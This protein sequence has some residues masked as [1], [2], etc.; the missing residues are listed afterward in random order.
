MVTASSSARLNIHDNLNDGSGSTPVVDSPGPIPT[1]TATIRMAPEPT[2]EEIFQAFKPVINRITEHLTCFNC[3]PPPSEIKDEIDEYA[4][5]CT[6]L[7]KFQKSVDIPETGIFDRATAERLRQPHCHHQGSHYEKRIELGCN[8]DPN[9]KNN[10]RYKFERYSDKLD[11]VEL[12]TVFITVFREWDRYHPRENKFIEVPPQQVADITIR[13]CEAYDDLGIESAPGPVDRGGFEKIRSWRDDLVTVSYYSQDSGLKAQVDIC[14]N[15]DKVSTINHLQ[16]V[17]FHH[18]GHLFG[19]NHAGVKDVNA[20]MWPRHTNIDQP[21]A[22][23]LHPTDVRLIRALYKSET[24]RAKGKWSEI[25]DPQQDGVSQIAAASGNRLYRL[26]KSGTV[27]WYLSNGEWRQVR[28]AHAHVTYAGAAQ[29][30][31]GASSLYIL[32]KNGRIWSMFHSQPDDLINLD[33]EINYSKI[34]RA[35]RDGTTVYQLQGEDHGVYERRDVFN[36]YWKNLGENNSLTNTLD[37]IT[38]RSNLFLV[39]SDGSIYLVDGSGRP[40]RLIHKKCKTAQLVGAGR[41]LYRLDESGELLE[42]NESSRIWTKLKSDPMNTGISIAATESH[43]Y[44]LCKNGEIRYKDRRN[45]QLGSRTEWMKLAD[46]GMGSIV[47]LTAADS[48]LY[49]L[50]EDGS[51]HR[52]TL[53]G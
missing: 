35:V 41:S 2:A 5:L 53:E 52:F 21:A 18:V 8:S 17:T 22:T 50:V 38:N 6:G 10:I 51:I 7:V 23:T 43:L 39:H 16:Q 24:E 28:I 45:D 49:C 34:I 9:L 12:R 44:L 13:F 33:N 3:F 30:D 26:D 19:L 29:I 1:A 42:W 31:V 40:A 46:L 25:L 48:S 14:F 36:S 32:E 11:I 15:Q 4:E 27:W 37:I 47:Q 20:V